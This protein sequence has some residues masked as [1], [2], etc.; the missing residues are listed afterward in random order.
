MLERIV[1]CVVNKHEVAE[2][3]VDSGAHGSVLRARQHTGMGPVRSR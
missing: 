2:G 1:K 3:M